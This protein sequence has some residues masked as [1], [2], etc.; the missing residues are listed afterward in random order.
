MGVS[1]D[2]GRLHS[3]FGLWIMHGVCGQDKMLFQ[4]VVRS[5]VQST[6]YT[7]I[8]CHSWVSKYPMY[9]RPN[10]PEEGEIYQ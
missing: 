9:L 4:V 10:G 1:I 2:L 3:L 8:V 5:G 6:L 7:T